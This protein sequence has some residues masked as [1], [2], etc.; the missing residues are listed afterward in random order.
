MGKSATINTRI[1]EKTKTQAQSILRILNIPMSEAISMFFKQ[2]VLHKGIPFEIKIPNDV[3]VETFEKTD[4]G[5][6]LQKV[7]SIEELAKELKS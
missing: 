6:E 1:D 7:S 3:T 5:K 2:I 4:A